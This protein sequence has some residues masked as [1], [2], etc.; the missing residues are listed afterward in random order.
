M[1]PASRDQGRLSN[2]YIRWRKIADEDFLWWVD[3]RDARKFSEKFAN[4]LAHECRVR[5]VRTCFDDPV[6]AFSARRRQEL[7][8]A[9]LQ[10]AACAAGRAKDSALRKARFAKAKRLLPK[11]QRDEIFRQLSAEVARFRTAHVESLVNELLPLT[12][13]KQVHFLNLR[14][15]AVRPLEHRR[16]SHRSSQAGVPVGMTTERP[17]KLTLEEVEFDYGWQFPP[18]QEANEKRLLLRHELGQETAGYFA[19]K[20]IPTDSLY[21][22]RIA[23]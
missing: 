15:K 18:P 1:K 5:L 8:P 12:P 19:R 11:R 22:C 16:R 3:G 2:R 4:W 23:I 10:A 21:L 6:D 7:Y 20:K 17:T 9:R 14:I 13:A